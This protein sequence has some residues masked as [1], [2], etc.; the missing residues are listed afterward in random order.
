MAAKAGPACSV[1]G[2][3]EVPCEVSS[4]VAAFRAS[5]ER[6]Q[7]CLS[8]IGLTVEIGTEVHLCRQHGVLLEVALV[9]EYRC[10]TLYI[11]PTA[12]RRG[13]VFRGRG[14]QVEGT[15]PGP[16][17]RF[18]TWP[19]DVLGYGPIGPEFLLFGRTPAHRVSV[20]VGGV[21]LVG[22]WSSG[23]GGYVNLREVS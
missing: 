1:C 2:C 17:G 21:K 4:L 5:D 22:V 14:R 12:T 13:P 6:A 23:G 9:Q 18:T 8:E 3:V 20:V 16:R 19:G 11:E 15:I 7:K 10:A